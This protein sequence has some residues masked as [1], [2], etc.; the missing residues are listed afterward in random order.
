VKVASVHCICVVGKEIMVLE[1]GA[2]IE[3]DI[4]DDM[5]VGVACGPAA[6]PICKCKL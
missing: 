1:D 2:E 4:V 6:D 3:E 5:V